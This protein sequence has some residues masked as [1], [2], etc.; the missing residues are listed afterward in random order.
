MYST[1]KTESGINIVHPDE[2]TKAIEEHRANRSNA[3]ITSLI[4]R[5]NNTIANRLDDLNKSRGTKDIGAII[6][7]DCAPTDST[8]VIEEVARQLRVV[9]YTVKV[10]HDAGTYDGPGYSSGP[11]DW[12]DIYV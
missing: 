1:V 7:V 8:E 12:F 6:R 4:A 3:L 10:R 5:V 11:S 9:G 2:V